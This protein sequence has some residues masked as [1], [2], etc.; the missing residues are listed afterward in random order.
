MMTKKPN[1]GPAF[2]QPRPDY[3][4]AYG[5]ANMPFGGMS[6]RDWFA[7][8]VLNGLL[9]DSDE[10]PEND[11]TL[12]D[13]AESIAAGAYQMADAMLKARGE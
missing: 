5:G 1:G 6:L 10:R 9:S 8:Q 13:F 2:P 7:G 11:E 3:S 12:E 4:Q